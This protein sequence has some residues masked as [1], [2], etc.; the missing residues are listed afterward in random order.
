MIA[1]K[2]ALYMLIIVL[3]VIIAAYLIGKAAAS[4]LRQVR[5]TLERSYSIWNEG[6]M[7]S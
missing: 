1:M 2:N 3:K 5:Q 6:S 4:R 7:E